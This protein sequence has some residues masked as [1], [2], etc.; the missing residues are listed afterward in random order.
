MA[1]SLSGG[2]G[3]GIYGDNTGTGSGNADF[4]E[5]ISFDFV[6][7]SLG[8]VYTFLTKTWNF[9]ITPLKDS[10]GVFFSEVGLE[11]EFI[12]SLAEYLSELLTNTLVG[13]M[14][15]MHIVF[16]SLI[17]YWVFRHLIKLLFGV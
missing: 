13:E 2:F 10:S 12:S 5:L 6:L 9:M 4:K 16:G 15:P 17:Y 3:G 7:D 1:G 8:K 11:S 14:T